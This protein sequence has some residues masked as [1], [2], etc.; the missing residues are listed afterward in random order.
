MDEIDYKL[1]T[2]NPTLISHVN[3][4]IISNID[5]IYLYLVQLCYSIVFQQAI[6]KLIDAIKKKLETEEKDISKVNNFNFMIIMC[7]TSFYL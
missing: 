6:S 2:Q 3:I 7:N 1:K 5:Y 4:S